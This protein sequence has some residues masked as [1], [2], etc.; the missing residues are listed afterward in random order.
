MG[1]GYKCPNGCGRTLHWIKDIGNVSVYECS[2]CGLITQ[3]IYP[4]DED[5]DSS[6]EEES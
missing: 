6:E 4:D 3:E 2:Q 5:S 1:M